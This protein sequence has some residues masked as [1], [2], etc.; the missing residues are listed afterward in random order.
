M[1]TAQDVDGGRQSPFEDHYDDCEDFDY[2]QCNSELSSIGPRMGTPP[3]AM[4]S[5]LSQACGLQHGLGADVD[6]G[7]DEVVLRAPQPTKLGPHSSPPRWW[8]T[9]DIDGG[10]Q[11]PFSEVDDYDYDSCAGPAQQS[12]DHGLVL[13]HASQ[14]PSSRETSDMDLVADVLARCFEDRAAVKPRGCK[15]HGRPSSAAPAWKRRMET[16]FPDVSVPFWCG[17]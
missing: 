17:V 7:R 5:P 4:D 11:S 14:G 8:P 2:G 1:S 6:M 9:Y 3:Q 15:R 13:G 16:P 10:R 12:S